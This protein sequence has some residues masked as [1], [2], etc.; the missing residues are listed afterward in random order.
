VNILSFSESLAGVSLPGTTAV[1]APSAISFADALQAAQPD[2]P[3]EVPTA[4]CE[5]PQATECVLET[6]RQ[7]TAETPAPPIFAARP[8]SAPSL[9]VTSAVEA[10]PQPTAPAMTAPE[11][12]ALP[13]PV[14]SAVIVALQPERVL[15]DLEAEPDPAEPSNQ[16]TTPR[17]VPVGPP[18]AP[19]PSL[20]SKRPRAPEEPVEQ[21]QAAYEPEQASSAAEQQVEPALEP[22]PVAAARPR[23]GRNSAKTARA[24]KSAGIEKATPEA[25]PPAPVIPAAEVVNQKPLEQP[26]ES[27][28]A[29]HAKVSKQ[30]P[31]RAAQPQKALPQMGL[32]QGSLPE[33][34]DQATVQPQAATE[35]TVSREP[36][37]PWPAADGQPSVL[38]AA[39]QPP[40]SLQVAADGKSSVQTVVAQ[41]RQELP[42]APTTPIAMDMTPSA[43]VENPVWTNSQ[44][45]EPV[46]PGPEVK[47]LPVP[48][49]APPS[50]PADAAT[51]P[52]GT[53]WTP[54]SATA[55]AVQTATPP[56]QPQADPSTAELTRPV[57]NRAVARPAQDAPRLAAAAVAFEV[58]RQLPLQTLS[59]ASAPPSQADPKPAVSSETVATQAQPAIASAEAAWFGLSATG[60]VQPGTPP[61]RKDASGLPTSFRDLTV[62]EVTPQPQPQQAAA[63]PNQRPLLVELMQRIQAAETG[64]PLARAVK[65][66]SEAPVK[67]GLEPLM[68]L[69]SEKKS[70]NESAS[71]LDKEGESP[72]GLPSSPTHFSAQSP[73]DAPKVEETAAPVKVLD[74]V[75]HAQ[76]LARLQG[77]AL[78]DK[79]RELE[80][81][82]HSHKLGE[83]AARVKVESDGQWS[84]HVQ[85]RDAEVER[86]VR[87]ELVQIQETRGLEGF[88]TSLSQDS[89][90]QRGS[91]QGFAFDQQ[92]SRTPLGL[93]PKKS[94]QPL[95]SADASPIAESSSVHGSPSGLNVRA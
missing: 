92:Q 59:Q 16:E 32:P 93:A 11:P 74:Q 80:V 47:P 77:K 69:L 76:H 70:R 9:P 68:A 83:V 35:T 37:D 28:E 78:I 95:T 73:S 87:Q 36:K 41:P 24:A 75:E 44:A 94:V 67:S 2:V 58:A 46:P 19:V 43:P 50:L 38:A 55:A 4:G 72:E 86:S 66:V 63:P 62:R 82:L 53:G 60:A 65:T 91:F 52:A 8:A 14:V 7:Q 5:I 54:P 85:L 21:E 45:P 31:P 20:K 42:Q 27:P 29:T 48:A 1:P 23:V 64:Q 22:E 26:V 61:E 40:V 88:T 33:A 18:A 81:H 30:T 49:D 51:F 6:L 25:A 17:P 15:P 56:A 57:R 84:A 89:R 71:E 10:L 39:A 13:S 79:P 12:E 90:D 34:P 3:A